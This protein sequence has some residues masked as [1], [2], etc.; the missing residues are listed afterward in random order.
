MAL[1]VKIKKGKFSKAY[2][3][4]T[5]IEAMKTKTWS[6]GEP[7]LVKHGLGYVIVFPPIDRQNQV[8]LQLVGKETEKYQI[9]LS[10]DLAGDYGNMAA[11]AILSKVTGGLSN[12]GSAFGKKAKAGEEAV[13]KLA[14]ELEAS[15]L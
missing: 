10:H 9:T 2:T 14:E 6:G 8:W 15:G 4:E 3:L 11:N 13:A 5:L 7:S 1:G 12:L